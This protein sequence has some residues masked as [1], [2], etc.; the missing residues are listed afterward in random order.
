MLLSS[1]R[2]INH[3]LVLK[4]L[5]SLSSFVKIHVVIALDFRINVRVFLLYVVHWRL[6]GHIGNTHGFGV[7]FK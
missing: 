5:Q 3:N 6:N 4:V 1:R 2:L 7:R